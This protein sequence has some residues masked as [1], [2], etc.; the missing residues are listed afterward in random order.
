MHN[1]K[2][3]GKKFIHRDIKSHNVF[4]TNDG[5]VKLGDFGI[6]RILEHSKSRA[7]SVSGTVYYFS[8]EM[9]K[10]EKYDESTDMWSLGVLLYYMCALKYPFKGNSVEDIAQKILEAKPGSIPEHYCKDLKDIIHGLLKKE[11]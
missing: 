8:P 11:P 10:G 9:I 5:M 6:S 1:H 3:H 2:V 4:L 7:S